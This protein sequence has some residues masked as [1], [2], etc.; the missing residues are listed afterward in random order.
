MCVGVRDPWRNPKFL[1]GCNRPVKLS[2]ISV[3]VYETR[4]D[5]RNFCMDIRDSQCRSKS[6]VAQDEN[7]RSSY[8]IDLELSDRSRE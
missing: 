2:K 3:W 1:C 6:Y 8:H 4:G 5:I 7:T